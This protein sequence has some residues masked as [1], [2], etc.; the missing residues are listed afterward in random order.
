MPL[1]RLE[2]LVVHRGS[3]KVLKGADLDVNEGEVVALLGPNGSGKTTVIWSAAGLLPLRE[4]R[5]LHRIGDV[6]SEVRRGRDGLHGN[7]APFGLCIQQGGSCEEETVD[8][9][10]SLALSLNGIEVTDAARAKWLDHWGLGHRRHDR[11]GWLS[12]GLRR[13]LEAASAL[14]PAMASERP[15]AVLLDEPSEGLDE[16]GV[17]TLRETI[18][19][20]ASSGAGVLLATHD[21]RL[22]PHATRSFELIDGRLDP[23]DLSTFGGQDRARRPSDDAADEAVVGG[24]L[25][26]L[27]GGASM[28]GDRDCPQRAWMLGWNARL[29]LRTL[30]TP[31]ARWV[32]GLLGLAIFAGLGLD[33]ATMSMESAAGL[34]LAPALI[35]ALL[36]PSLADRLDPR[37]MGAFWAAAHQQRTGFQIVVASASVSPA[38]IAMIGW[39][40]FAP[41]GWTGTAALWIAPLCALL[42]IDVAASAGSI[43]IRF[44]G[45]QRPAV[46]ALL[47]LP[48]AWILL[49]LS[50]SLA[51]AMMDDI[52]GAL[53]SFAAAL[54]LTW[55]IAAAVLLIRE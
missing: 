53:R 8:E 54:A 16:D 28:M 3:R 52:G 23:V 24:V 32:P 5:L 34:S 35:A 51:N 9:H 44:G 7:A 48:F 10:L 2:S 46:A 31:A 38:M 37:E 29:D 40:M 26:R 11:I 36:R 14:A 18:T 30:S 12:G 41:S 17:K 39:L 22:V 4:G 49:M 42:M 21:E 43:H 1:L 47:L 6:L 50:S 33:S 19:A 55:L 25:E 20:A 27:R 13:R 45:G 15:M